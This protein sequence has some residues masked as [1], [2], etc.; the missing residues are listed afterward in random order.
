[1]RIL[2]LICITFNLTVSAVYGSN[3][4]KK[5]LTTKQLLIDSIKK[6]FELKFSKNIDGVLEYSSEFEFIDIDGEIGKKNFSCRPLDSFINSIDDFKNI[7]LN[8][9]EK[10]IFHMIN[11][12]KTAAEVSCKNTRRINKLSKKLVHKSKS[13]QKFI[14]IMKYDVLCEE[15]FNKTLNK[16]ILSNMKE[17]ISSTSNDDIIFKDALYNYIGQIN[18][19][20]NNYR[21]KDDYDNEVWTSTFDELDVK[22]SLNKINTDSIAVKSYEHAFY[23]STILDNSLSEEYNL[24]C[25]NSNRSLVSYNCQLEALKYGLKKARELI[26]AD[27][28]K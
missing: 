26:K 2:I 10:L 23:T 11:D 9:S 28:Y 12:L 6:E 16:E 1:M 7:V 20:N 14:S 4:D 15:R 18:I 5:P 13:E 19:V 21:A 8:N 17:R 25:V 27:E 24:S 22:C 3:I